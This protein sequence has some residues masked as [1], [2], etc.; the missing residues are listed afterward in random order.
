MS[1]SLLCLLQVFFRASKFHLS[2]YLRV[3]KYIAHGSPGNVTQVKVI[4]CTASIFVHPCPKRH[5]TRLLTS[6]TI[7]GQSFQSLGGVKA[8]T[9]VLKQSVINSAV[10]SLQQHNEKGI[11]IA[12]ICLCSGHIYP[13]KN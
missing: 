7:T 4:K 3:K 9:V 10:H 1:G 11:F 2:C 8:L 12:N 13:Y 6:R 5:K